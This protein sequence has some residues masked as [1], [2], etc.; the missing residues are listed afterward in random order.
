MDEPTL[1]P[2]PVDGWSFIAR[3]QTDGTWSVR[4]QPSRSGVGFDAGSEYSHLSLGEVC[5]VICSSLWSL[6]DA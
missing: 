5:D 2:I 4:A 3:L 6:P 1:F